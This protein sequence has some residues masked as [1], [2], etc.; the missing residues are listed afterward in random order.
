MAA[1]TAALAFLGGCRHGIQ[2]RSSA[3]ETAVDTLAVESEDLMAE[4]FE[5]LSGDSFS[6][7]LERH[8]V[9]PQAASEV[10]A[11]A[12][13]IF[14]IRK[15]RA[16][17]TYRICY[18][19]VDGERVPSRIIYEKT[20]MVGI[21]FNVMSPYGV[22]VV[23]KQVDKRVK[24]AEVTIN[25]SLW[26]DAQKAGCP[27]DLISRIS[28]IYQWTIN[29][30][31][32]Q[33]GDSFKVLYE[34]NSSEGV[35]IGTGEII[36]SLFCHAG[37]EYPCWM[38][39]SGDEQS[40]RYWGENGESMRKAFLKA[41]LKFSRISSGFSYAR[42]HPITQRVQAHTAVDYAA[43]KGTP[44][45]AIGDG[46]VT[47]AKYEG[48]AGNMV[49][50]TH[51]GTYKTAYLHLSKYGPS[52]RAG[53]KVR[54]GQVIGYV[55]STGRS[56]GPHLDFRVWKNGT[57]INPLTMESPKTD[58][59]PETLMPAFREQQK[60]ASVMVDSTIAAILYDRVVIAPLSLESVSD[61]E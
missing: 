27:Q 60:R 8:A 19:E 56:T 22:E 5:V 2:E 44:V 20:P 6:E 28:D 51:N 45:V 47:S 26:Y 12:E 33:K 31:G 59:L 3:V 34:E 21:V 32:L 40:D 18:E 43:P 17:N 1:L 35:I 39:D 13:G 50:I 38:F 15:I 48:A 14:D 23:E 41:P 49:R 53:A 10:I 46:T 7:I 57:P 9:A 54:Q 58:P 11:N 25:N 30:F 29:F 4:E 24:Y 42:K 55:G 61:S 37:K 52:I 16:G 36:Y